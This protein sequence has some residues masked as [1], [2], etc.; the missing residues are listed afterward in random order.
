MKEKI[1]K[2]Q[3]IRPYFTTHALGLMVLGLILLS[4]SWSSVKAIQKNHELQQ[5][6]DQLAQQNDVQALEN[7]TQALRNKFYT[8]DEYLELNARRQF[9]KAA[10]GEKLVMIDKEV[11]KSYLTE[12]ATQQTATDSTEPTGWHKN[13]TAW[14]NFFFNR[15]QN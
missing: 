12:G 6:A 8:T 5:Q 3:A 14:L 15:T 7:E 4:V 9:G 1:Q 13:L 11:A 10:A 2:L